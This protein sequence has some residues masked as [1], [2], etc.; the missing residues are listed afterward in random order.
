MVRCFGSVCIVGRKTNV[1]RL[2]AID[3][4]IILAF[5]GMAVAGF[6]GF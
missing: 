4:I 2:K 5:I 6:Y 3:Y 1:K